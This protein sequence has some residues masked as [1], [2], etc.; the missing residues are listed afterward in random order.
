[1]AQLL[2]NI[3]FSQR[4]RLTFIESIA[5]WEGA[6]D[7]TR[8]SAAFKVSE[9]HVTK[10]FRLYKE[11]FPGNLQYDE[12]HRAYKPSRRFKPYI[13][14]GSA[15]E[16]L[17]LLRSH[18]EQNNGHS[19]PLPESIQADVTPQ[20]KGLLKT[21]ILNAFTRAIAAGSGLSIQYQSM[22]SGKPRSRKIWPHALVFGGTRW[23]AR[24]YDAERERW[25]DIVLQRVLSAK[26]IAD[27]H[28]LSDIQDKE[29]E[30]RITIEVIPKR[31]LTEDQADVVAQEFGMVRREERW[32]WEVNLRECL[33]G[34]FIYLYRLD[35]KGDAHRRIELNDP[36]IADKYLPP[37]IQPG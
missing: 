31:G 21:A 20:P 17:S 36:A 28:P 29:W 19:V 30:T 33:A 7:R 15:E 22:N 27:M 23:H 1:M 9:N 2:D 5:Y 14:Q 24:A 25:I 32:V 3:C 16:Y 34:Y 12:S 26:L 11:A 13:G 18:V 35:V 10:D 4:Q 8:V 6:V 37:M